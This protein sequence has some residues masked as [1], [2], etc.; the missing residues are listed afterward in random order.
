MKKMEKD[1]NKKFWYGISIGTLG[2]IVAII[3]AVLTLA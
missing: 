1:A 3:I 2:I